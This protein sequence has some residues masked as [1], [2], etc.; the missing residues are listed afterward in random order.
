M[1][2]DSK[3]WSR[4]TNLTA[5]KR[6]KR[7]LPR[8][9]SHLTPSPPGRTGNGPGSRAPWP[10]NTGAAV[11]STGTIG[12]LLRMMCRTWSAASNLRQSTED[13]IPRSAR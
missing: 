11:Y 8:S 5:L 1:S 12:R 13:Q 10:R 3:Q 2:L 9:E 6:L 7:C 4:P